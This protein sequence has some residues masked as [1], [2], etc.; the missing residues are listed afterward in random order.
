M[1]TL[2]NRVKVNTATQGTGT[3]QLGSAVD[4]FQTF[5]DGGVTNGQTVRYT[6]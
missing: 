5:A 6:I 1:V 2:A 4:T 3:I